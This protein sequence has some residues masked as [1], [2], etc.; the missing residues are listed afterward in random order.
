MARLQAAARS[1]QA[2][3]LGQQLQPEQQRLF[4]LQDNFLQVWVQRGRMDKVETA[5]NDFWRR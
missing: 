4:E 1:L 5:L 2:Q 3:L